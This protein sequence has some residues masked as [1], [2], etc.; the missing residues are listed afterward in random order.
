MKKWNELN[1]SE[2]MALIRFYPEDA[3]N[4]DC[5]DIRLEAYRAL[6]YTAEAFNDDD[7]IIRKDFWQ[8]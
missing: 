8:L 4:D 7:W 5:E 2:K 1:Y 6:G 3:L